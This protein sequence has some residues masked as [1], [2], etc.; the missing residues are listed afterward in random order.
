VNHDHHGGIA[1]KVSVCAAPGCLRPIF[2]G[3]YIVRRAEGGWRHEDC[4]KPG[5]A[6]WVKSRSAAD[7]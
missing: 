6:K 5:R 1:R 3:H 7:E 2:P 4:Q